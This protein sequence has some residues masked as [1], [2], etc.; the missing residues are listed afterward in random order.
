MFYG[1]SHTVTPHVVILVLSVCV[2]PTLAAAIS[3]EDDRRPNI[4][5]IL[6]DDLG[7]GDIGYHDTGRPLA[8]DERSGRQRTGSGQPTAGPL[9][10][11]R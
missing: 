7:W 4:V 1:R 9:E 8:G 10:K 11:A 3:A 2:F 6:A 5:F